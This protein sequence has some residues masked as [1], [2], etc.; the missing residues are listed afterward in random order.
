MLACTGSSGILQCCR[1]TTVW[2]ASGGLERPVPE[3]VLVG[4]NSNIRSKPEDQ[5]GKASGAQACGFHQLTG[6]ESSLACQGD[7]GHEK[8]TFPPD[9]I[10]V[11]HTSEEG[12]ISLALQTGKGGP[13]ADGNLCKPSVNQD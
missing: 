10:P 9:L 6:M 7:K 1:G 5:M 12:V 8:R 13:E 4:E 11:S 2:A 3:L